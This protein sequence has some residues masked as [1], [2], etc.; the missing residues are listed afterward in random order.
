MV[1]IKQSGRAEGFQQFFR[2]R[3]DERLGMVMQR[4]AFQTWRVGNLPFLKKSSD[5]GIE[6]CELVVAEDG[7]LDV[8]YSY[9]QT[10]VAG[11]I[12][13]LKQQLANGGKHL[14]VTV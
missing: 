6:R 1:G 3:L 4:D 11:A 5:G 9:L 8:R 14:P 12:R 7:A 13:R 2:E 10:A